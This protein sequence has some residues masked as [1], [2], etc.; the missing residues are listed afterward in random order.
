[1]NAIAAAP[2]PLAVDGVFGDGTFATLNGADA[3]V[4]YSRLRAAR[5]AYYQRLVEAKPTLGRFLQGWVNRVDAFPV[6]P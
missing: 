4:L 1:M 3:T 2:T 5:I 6:T